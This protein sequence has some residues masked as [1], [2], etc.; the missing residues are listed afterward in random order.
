MKHTIQDVA[1]EAC[2]SITTVSRVINNN[3]PVKAATRKK[4]EE[5]IQKLN[6]KPNILARSLINQKTET[7]GIIVPSITN[8]FFT[9]V[10]KG[11]EDLLRKKGYTIYLCN[12][13]NDE[14]EEIRYCKSLTARQVDGIIIIG[15]RTA[16]IKSGFFEELSQEIPLVCIN[17]YNKG[18][19]CNFVLN[20][21]ESGAYEAMNHLVN[22]GHRNIAFVRGD[23]SYSY[24]LK[25]DVYRDVLREND[26]EQYT[27]IVNIG[28]GNKEETVDFTV[29]KICQVLKEEKE[30]SAFFCCNDYMALGVLNACKIM[31]LEV[32]S[33]ISVIGFDNIS[34]CNLVQPKITTVDQNMYL[35][36][37]KAAEMIIK[38]IEK[39]SEQIEKIILNTKLVIN[40]STDKLKK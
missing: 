38:I 12:T 36:G 39:E 10:V 33:Q 16:N 29:E 26:Y 14:N 9:V 1:R 24:D 15:P 17:G 30:I 13:D 40:N 3:Y 19:K 2:V 20:D 23:K 21:E 31:N 4:V 28:A 27:N 6:F 8:L 22:L 18:V 5:A 32:P 37:K 7:I 25:E 35:L 34:I 11:I